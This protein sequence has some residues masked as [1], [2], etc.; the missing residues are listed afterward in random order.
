MRIQRRNWYDWAIPENQTLCVCGARFT[1]DH[2]MIYKRG[3]FI[4]QRHNELRDL[5]EELLNMVCYVVK[6]KPGKS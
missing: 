4:M 6:V 5:E 2:A 1:I 3:G